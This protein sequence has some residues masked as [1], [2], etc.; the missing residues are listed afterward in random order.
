MYPLERRTDARDCALRRPI[1]FR[2]KGVQLQVG[3]EIAF[4]R[5]RKTGPD[6]ELDVQAKV[7]AEPA[8]KDAGVVLLGG[9]DDAWGCCREAR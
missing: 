4:V 3:A 7:A 6:P 8:I 5:A 1:G 2:R 9:T